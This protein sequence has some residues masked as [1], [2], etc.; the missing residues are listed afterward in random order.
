MVACE[1]GHLDVVRLLVENQANVCVK[2]K[3]MCTFM[4]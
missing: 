4:F 3:V 2:N 1:N